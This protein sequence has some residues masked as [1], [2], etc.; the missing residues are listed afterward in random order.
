[1]LLS[2][3][4]IKVRMRIGLDPNINELQPLKMS[5]KKMR[6]AQVNRTQVCQSLR[7]LQVLIREFDK[8]KAIGI[9]K[10]GL[11]KGAYR[12]EL[13]RMRV[14]V[15]KSGDSGSLQDYTTRHKSALTTHSKRGL[16]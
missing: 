11:C 3:C 12:I 16:K 5:I 8:L 7:H 9:D 15:S 10:M 4:R 6:E 13:H 1:M 2:R 14:R